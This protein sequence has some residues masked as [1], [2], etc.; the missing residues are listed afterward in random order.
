MCSISICSYGFV[1]FVLIKNDNIGSMIILSFNLV[2]YNLHPWSLVSLV[3]DDFCALTLC[4]LVACVG[5][6]MI[7]VF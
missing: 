2:G 3:D 5:L 1:I 6:M 7:I 4:L